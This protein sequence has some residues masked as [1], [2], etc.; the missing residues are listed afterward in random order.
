MEAARPNSGLAALASAVVV[1][2]Q[3]LLGFTVS[4]LRRIFVDKRIT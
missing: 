1:A 4:V 2:A 3:T